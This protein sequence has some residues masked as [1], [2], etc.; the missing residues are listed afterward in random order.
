MDDAH[1]EFEQELTEQ[2][3]AVSRFIELPIRLPYTKSMLG[4]NFYNNHHHPALLYLL[5]ERRISYATQDLH[6]ALM[7]LVSHLSQF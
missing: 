7:V 5:Y 6:A 4:T 3:M 1:T 2:S